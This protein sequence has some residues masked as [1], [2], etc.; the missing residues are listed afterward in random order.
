MTVAI[1]KPGTRRQS[2][3]SLLRSISEIQFTYAVDSFS[4]AAQAISVINSRK[5]LL[6]IDSQSVNGG[7][8]AGIRQ[9][10][11][12]SPRVSCILLIEQPKYEA[13]SKI[14]GADAVLLEGFSATSFLDVALGLVL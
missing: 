14:E 13:A 9:I 5:I 4:E 6:L 10:K 2:I 12:I 3:C 11:K 1:I 8:E 7:L